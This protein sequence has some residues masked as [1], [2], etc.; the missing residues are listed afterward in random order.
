MCAT[1]SRR[2][3]PVLDWWALASALHRLASTIS[4]MVVL[5]I[6][7]YLVTLGELKDRQRDRLHWLRVAADQRAW[8]RSRPS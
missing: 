6:G 2:S 1:F 5:L 8:T 4:M 7:A 3:I